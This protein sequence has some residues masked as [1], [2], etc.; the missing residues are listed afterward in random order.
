MKE[1]LDAGVMAQSIFKLIFQQAIE[2]RDVVKYPTPVFLWADEAQYFL[3]PYDQIF[4]TTARSSRTSTVY[5][6]QN[7][8]NY[9][10]AMGGNSGTKAKVDSLM[11]NLS[12]KIFHANSDAES[13]EYASRL[14][15]NAISSLNNKGS[16]RSSF[17]LTFSTSE[18][19]T[20][21]NLP[22]IQPR[23]FTILKSG[24][25]QNNYS[26]ESIVFVTGKLWSTQ[27]N[28]SKAVFKQ[29]F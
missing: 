28:F 6:S 10:V 3:N 12:T 2:R 14:I 16:S 21:Q 22:Q 24:G 1:F 18:G 19:T 20:E 5:L 8:S 17:N 23:E 29:S 26:V 9:L 4:L 15:G 25:S 7:I 11:G 13:N 27:T